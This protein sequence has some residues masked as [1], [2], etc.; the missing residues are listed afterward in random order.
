VG[1]RDEFLA[2]LE[3]QREAEAAFH[4]GDPEPRLALWSHR[5][6]V[7]LFGAAGMV[8]SG[9]ELLEPSFR[10]VAATFSDVTAYSYEVEA[11]EVGADVAYAAGIE[12]FTGS[13]AGAPVREVVVRST[14][15]YR[16]E[17]GEWKI[18]H[19]HGDNPPEFD[20]GE[21]EGR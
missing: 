18:C 15:A 6:P 1:E 21:A 5:D 19:R 14:H 9:W 3:R 12:R 20:A 16:R 2:L 8:Q 11:Y 10:R 17:D 13:I 4:Q 7:T